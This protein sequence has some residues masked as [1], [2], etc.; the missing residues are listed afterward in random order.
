MKKIEPL[1]DIG[2]DLALRQLLYRCE[3]D[4]M[5]NF[6]ENFE[7]VSDDDLKSVIKY[8]KIVVS[9][10]KYHLGLFNQLA[11]YCGN[12]EHKRKIASMQKGAAGSI[13]DMERQVKEQC[14]ELQL[15]Q[16]VM[17]YGAITPKT[18]S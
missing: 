15:Q 10:A 3:R 7:A 11:E 2:F 9:L 16:T 12:A 17:L 14:T 6:Q 5:K 4:A 13:S 1:D 8:N 18:Y